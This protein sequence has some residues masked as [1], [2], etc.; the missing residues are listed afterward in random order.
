MWAA[1]AA[2]A[3]AQNGWT[4]LILTGWNGL[5]DC[6]R[7]LLDAGADKNAKGEVRASAGFDV[8]DIVGGGGDG[9]VLMVE[10]CHL[11]FWLQ[12]L[13]FDIFEVGFAL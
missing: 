11:H 12:V 3:A 2:A 9:L 7:L 1:A 5:A 4:A 8:R 10:A 6:A 13:I